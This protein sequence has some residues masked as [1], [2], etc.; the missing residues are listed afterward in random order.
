MLRV[1]YELRTNAA[2]ELKII[3][4]DVYINNKCTSFKKLTHQVDLKINFFLIYNI[5]I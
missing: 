2:E 3:Y 5:N 4:S 1:Q